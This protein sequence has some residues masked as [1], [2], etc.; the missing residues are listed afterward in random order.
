MNLEAPLTV[1]EPRNHLVKFHEDDTSL[2]E[3]AGRFLVEGAERGEGLIIIATA[4]H[5]R[6]FIAG[7]T[8]AGFDVDEM[9]AEG[10]LLVL[11]AAATLE[12]L[13]TDGTPDAVKFRS[14]LYGLVDQMLSRDGTSRIRA[15][16]EMVDLLAQRDEMGAALRLETYWNQLLRQR[17]VTLLCGYRVS[18]LD[19]GPA[20]VAAIEDVCHAH[21][22]VSFAE[23]RALLDH[24]VERAFEDEFG[25]TQA[26]ILRPLIVATLGPSNSRG[27]AEHLLFWLRRN[28]P[29]CLDTIMTTARR[30]YQNGQ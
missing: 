14:I 25:R 13:L 6:M 4:D 26:E 23:D 19:D 1:T 9:A 28:L 11:D 22:Q 29:D 7:L 8:A 30:H 24:A 2:R 17:P 27:D 15:F 18:L 3:A 21:S 10:R 16:G 20:K 12:A 5:G